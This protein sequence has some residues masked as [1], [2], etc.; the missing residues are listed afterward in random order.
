MS[1]SKR[2][3]A[4]VDDDASVRK[5]LKRL[6]CAAGFDARP[7][8]SAEEFLREAEPGSYACVI[9][10][11][12]L[13]GMSG[14]DLYRDLQTRGVRLPAI[15]ITADETSWEQAASL[16][17]SCM[18]CLHKPFSEHVLFEALNSVLSFPHHDSEDPLPPGKE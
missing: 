12:K 4:I 11:I 16:H 6:L 2:S 14:F 9:L 1:D 15:F 7:F 17:L 8:G 13:L 18:P 10:D 3:V 5:S